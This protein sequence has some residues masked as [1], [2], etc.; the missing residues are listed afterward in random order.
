ME[1]QAVLVSVEI[2]ALNWTVVTCEMNDTLYRGGQWSL[3]GRVV[4]GITV[5]IW[6]W[7]KWA[8]IALDFG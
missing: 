6:L 5:F 4:N 7:Q 8:Q 3:M 2:F 1:P